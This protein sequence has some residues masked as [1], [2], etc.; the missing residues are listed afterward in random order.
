MVA[1]LRCTNEVLH[2]WFDNADSDVLAIFVQRNPKY[3]SLSSMKTASWHVYNGDAETNAQE[4]DIMFWDIRLAVQLLR[5]GDGTILDALSSPAVYRIYDRVSNALVTHSSRPAASPFW[6]QQMRSTALQHIRWLDVVALACAEAWDIYRTKISP[7]A[8]TVVHKRYTH[9]ARRV[10]LALWILLRYRTY[11]TGEHP[12]VDQ[13][14][15][16]GVGCAAGH[17]AC[18]AEWTTQAHGPEHGLRVHILGTLPPVRVLRLTGA[19]AATAPLCRRAC[20]PIAG[21]TVCQ[22]GT[23]VVFPPEARAALETM[24]DPA[25]LPSLAC[26]GP[27]L[28]VL[29]AWFEDVIPRIQE[30]AALLQRLLQPTHASSSVPATDNSAI[31]RSPVDEKQC[32]LHVPMMTAGANGTVSRTQPIVGDRRFEPTALDASAF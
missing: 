25:A 23:V 11:Y 15:D 21:T 18:C 30:H 26:K 24:L 12:D 10:L 4:V 31:L 22:G 13:T 5:Q 14:P 16:A 8:P 9:A 32:M 17:A 20:A 3:M 28:P 27:R 7:H 1:S 19:V 29:D 2:I 6:L